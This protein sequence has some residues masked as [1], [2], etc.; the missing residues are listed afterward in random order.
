MEPHL[1]PYDVA[2]GTIPT[3]TTLALRHQRAWHT[4]DRAPHDGGRIKF[5]TTLTGSAG[6][7]NERFVVFG[8]GQFATICGN[9]IDGAPVWYNPTPGQ[10]PDST[11][12]R[13]GLVFQTANASGA[14]STAKF[15]GVVEF[16]HGAP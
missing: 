12:A 16:A 7:Y 3:M 9:G 1:H 8:L 11:Y 15:L 14:L 2:S 13:F 6:N 5:N 10:D 4:A